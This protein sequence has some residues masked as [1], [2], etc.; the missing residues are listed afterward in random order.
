MRKINL[1]ECLIIIIIIGISCAKD[2][3]LNDDYRDHLEG[4][5]LFTIHHTESV[6]TKNAFYK[7]LTTTDTTYSRDAV[8]EKASFVP[9]STFFPDRM[10]LIRSCISTL[11]GIR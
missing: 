9:D 4:E 7:K 1:L 2:E 8:I 10:I 3:V 5:F 11:V 6:I